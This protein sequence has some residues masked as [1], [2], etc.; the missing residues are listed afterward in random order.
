MSVLSA[1]LRGEPTGTPTGFNGDAVAVAK[2][3]LTAGEN[4]DGEGGFTVRGRLMPAGDSLAKGALPIGLAHDVPLVNDV[5]K[6]QVITWADVKVDE[7]S[8]AVKVRR[9]MEALFGALS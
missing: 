1:A 8:D 9:D 6:G 3:H 2:R 4:L 5:S 7:T